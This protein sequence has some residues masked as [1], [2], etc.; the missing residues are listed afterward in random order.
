MSLHCM[1]V[2]LCVLVSLVLELHKFVY[3]DIT[4]IARGVAV[5]KLVIAMQK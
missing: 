2:L 4:E 5:D 1:C 3:F